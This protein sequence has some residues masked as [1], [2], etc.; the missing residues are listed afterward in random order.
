MI[1]SC[2]LLLSWPSA[3]PRRRGKEYYDGLTAFTRQQVVG[4][5]D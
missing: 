2:L 4:S 3:I 1:G 5:P